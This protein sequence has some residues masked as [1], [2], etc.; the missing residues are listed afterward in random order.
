MQV[1]INEF[2]MYY[3]MCGAGEPLLRLHGFGGC[4]GD[5]K[6]IFNIRHDRLATRD[7]LLLSIEEERF[8]LSP[9]S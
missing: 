6:Y 1:S 2:E 5:W 7:Y 8:H 3:E 9:E 4:G